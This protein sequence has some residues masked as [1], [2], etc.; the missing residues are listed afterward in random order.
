M[1]GQNIHIDKLE[2]RL[3][4][5]SKLSARQIAA[6]LGNEILSQI[7]DLPKGQNKAGR[8]EKLDVGKIKRS[9]NSSVSD[10][11]RQIAGKVV[12]E[13]RKSFDKRSEK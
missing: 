6:G 13:V 11:Q 4:K 3:P 9:D 8:I 12:S 10:L 7:A 2:I 5:G 1:K